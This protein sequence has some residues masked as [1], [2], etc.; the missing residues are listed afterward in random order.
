M[1]RRPRLRR[2]FE[3]QFGRCYL[4]GG[5]M[6][7]ETGQDNTATIDHR[8]PKSRFDITGEAGAPDNKAAACHACNQ[9]KGDL[10]DQEYWTTLTGPEVSVS[11]RK[12]GGQARRKSDMQ[13][14]CDAYGRSG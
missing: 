7:L 5:A 11:A 12:A 14:A 3:R 9:A 2:L 8:L 1:P 4:C 10:T 13:R 6:V